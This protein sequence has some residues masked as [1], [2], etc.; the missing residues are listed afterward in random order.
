MMDVHDKDTAVLS[1]SVGTLDIASHG[2]K[3]LETG[4]D[5]KTEPGASAPSSPPVEPITTSGSCYPLSAQKPLH[6]SATPFTTDSAGQLDQPCRVSSR[7]FESESNEFLASLFQA[8][9]LEDHLV[10]RRSPDSCVQNDFSE[11]ITRLHS[12]VYSS[13]SDPL[14]VREVVFDKDEDEYVFKNG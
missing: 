9:H 13:T 7:V 3:T 2:L 1:G 4:L 8:E 11:E 6:L 14:V 5:A 10:S 12:L